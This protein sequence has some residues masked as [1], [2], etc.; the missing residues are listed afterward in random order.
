MV[1]VLACA[2]P[3]LQTPSGNRDSGK[4]RFYRITMSSSIQVIWNARCET[5]EENAPFSL[6]QI[7]N[8]WRSKIKKRLELDCLMTRNRFGK[9]ALHKDLVI[10][11]WSGSILNEHQ[12]PQDWTEAN[13]VLVG[14]E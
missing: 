4:E 7:C 5:R 11:T 10:K 13:G 9:K 8:R 3:V 12:L 2:V 6:E 14:T 1:N